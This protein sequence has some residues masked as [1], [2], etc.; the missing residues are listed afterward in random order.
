[1]DS[2]VSICEGLA[3]KRPIVS[4]TE[5]NVKELE[6]AR[7]TKNQTVFIQDFYETERLWLWGEDEVLS[8][9]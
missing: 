3:L 2:V 1:M 7:K 8:T 4:L 6:N 5:K 9:L